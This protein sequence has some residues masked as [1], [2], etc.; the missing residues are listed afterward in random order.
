[1]HIDVHPQACLAVLRSFTW[2]LNA[3]A[4]ER[5]VTRRTSCLKPLIKI[6]VKVF[7]PRVD[8]RRPEMHLVEI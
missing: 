5:Q 1:M 6:R 2:E 8:P 4:S 7:T 3:T